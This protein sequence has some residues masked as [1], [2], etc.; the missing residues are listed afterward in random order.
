MRFNEPE[1]ASLAS[2]IT[3]RFDKEGLLIITERQESIFRRSDV[4]LEC[5]CKLRGNLLFY[6]KDKNPKSSVAGAVVLQD[7]QPRIHNDEPDLEGYV[8]DLDFKDS[9]SQRIGTHSAADRLDW[10]R[11]IEACSNE[12]IDLQIKQLQ[13]QIAAATTTT[14]GNRINQGLPLPLPLPMAST[15]LTDTWRASSSAPAVEAPFEGDLI[16]F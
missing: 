9:P 6:L 4:K 14:M 3:T 13:E 1:L 11:S 2:N 12:Q 5:W 15:M 16:Q 7:C 8:F 10:V